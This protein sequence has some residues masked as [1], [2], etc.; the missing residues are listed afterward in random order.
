VTIT[1]SA[2][3]SPQKITLKGTGI[4]PVTFNPTQLGF[5]G[6]TVG[7]TS[8]PLTTTLTNHEKT[9]L[10]VS[11]VSIIGANG[12]DFAQSNTCLPSV[13]AGGTC[14]ITVRFTP[15]AAGSRAG[16]LVVTDDASTSPQSVKLTG[17][18]Q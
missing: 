17:S 12:G 5:G 16:T 13:S 18:G 10:N 9:A 2:N 7:T 11:A 4:N 6:V 3:N 8:N 1:D 14:S 15:S